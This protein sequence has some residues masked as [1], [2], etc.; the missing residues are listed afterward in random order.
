MEWL[1]WKWEENQLKPGKYSQR[2]ELSLLCLQRSFTS[3][4]RNDTGAWLLADG[5]ICIQKCMNIHTQ[6]PSPSNKGKCAVGVPASSKKLDLLWQCNR[7]QHRW[8]AQ[9][10]PGR[11]L[12]L[13]EYV[14]LAQKFP[15][16]GIMTPQQ[17]HP[18]SARVWWG[19][20][21]V[22]QTNWK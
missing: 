5:G 18:V 19:G 14:P 3:G 17:A 15:N 1:I 13:S 16:W 6:T 22:N 4:V 12:N 10:K 21:V 9:K 7:K 11:K 20:G 8:T 2:M